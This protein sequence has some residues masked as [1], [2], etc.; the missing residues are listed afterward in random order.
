MKNILVASKTSRVG[1]R[2]EE[3]KKL[4]I[5]HG[6]NPT[7]KRLKDCDDQLQEYEGIVIGTECIEAK[8]IDR[9]KKLK[10]IIKFGVGTDNIDRG[11]AEKRH[12]KV[13]NMPG[14]N[15][16]AVAEM[17]LSLMLCVSRRVA[18]GDRNIRGNLWPGLIG[19]SPRNKTLGIIGT[20]SIG[21]ELSKLVTGFDMKII[22]YDIVKNEEFKHLGGRYVERDGL[23]KVSDYISIHVPLN[24]YTY[25]FVGERELSLMKES[26][27]ILNTSRGGIIDESA[28]YNA[29]QRKQILGAGLD[30]LEFEPPNESPLLKL[31]H[32]VFTPHIA[33][34]DYE[35]L[36]NMNYTC[37]YRLKKELEQQNLIV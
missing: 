8:H 23:F 37:A 31:D 18:E 36:R 12:V 5:D 28:L 22:G 30:V 24:Q 21:R 11:A 20:G 1:M 33:A 16:Y 17:A 10:V 25:H 35:T 4:F 14:I 19:R 2:E 7:F 26:A 3:L 34:Y 15:S 13:L 27:I 6:L 29:L 9:A 32:V